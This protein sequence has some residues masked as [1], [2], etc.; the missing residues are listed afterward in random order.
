[1]DKKEKGCCGN[2]DHDHGQG[3]CGNH[4]EDKKEKGCCGHDHDHNHD[5]GQGCCG[6]DHDHE[7]G[8]CD[9]QNTITLSLDNGDEMVCDVLAIF[10][11]DDEEV[12]YIALLPQGKEDVLIY[13]FKEDEEGIDL[14]NIEDD[15]EFERVSK[16]F[17]EEFIQEDFE[18]EEEEEEN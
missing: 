11:I 12:E 1:M 16:Y 17:M 9:E 5:H 10:S 3:C 14:E 8:C 7:E 15:A 13:L 18:N 2:H 4:G 6:H